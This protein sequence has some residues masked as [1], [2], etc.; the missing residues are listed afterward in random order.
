M[1]EQ[2]ITRTEDE[3]GA[4]TP[5]VGS[6]RERTMGFSAEHKQVWVLEKPL[7]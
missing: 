3:K 5:C 6:E 4:G 2:A 1:E 7:S